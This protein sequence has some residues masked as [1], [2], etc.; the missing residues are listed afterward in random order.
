MNIDKNSAVTIQYK[1]SDTQGRLLEESK[2]PVAYLHGGYGNIF[3]KVE[4]ALQGKQ[5]GDQVSVDLAAADAFGARDESLA[6]T[7]PKADFPPGIKVG[8]QLERHGDDGHIHVF[9]VLKIK[10]P[11]VLLDGNHPLAGK[12]LT[13]AIKVIEVRAAKEEEIAHGHVHG[14][15]GHHH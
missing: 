6:I 9:T 3:S 8:G 7:I 1:L 12:D 15:H 11:Q 14:A 4:E 2:Q 13:M 10:G 5:S